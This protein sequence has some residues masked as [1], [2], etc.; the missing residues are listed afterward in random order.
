MKQE[1]D[2][3][4]FS[5]SKKLDRFTPLAFKTRSISSSTKSSSPPRLENALV[6]FVLV[7]VCTFVNVKSA[8][9]FGGAALVKAPSFSSK[10][11]LMFG[12]T[13]LKMRGGKHLKR[14][15]RGG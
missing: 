7:V 15:A 6:V 5:I 14:S 9:T 2:M 12:E 11:I 3:L 4:F 10:V 1:Q 13:Y 8:A